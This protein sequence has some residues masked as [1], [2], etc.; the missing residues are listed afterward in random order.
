MPGS[1][2]RR[3]DLEGA[4]RRVLAEGGE[5]RAA[6]C[7]FCEKR[8]AEALDLADQYANARAVEHIARAI[9]PAVGRPGIS[10]VPEPPVR[11]GG[12]S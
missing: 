4:I 9:G 2:Y 12:P 6:P 3:A 8:I 10:P 1:D 7:Q 11:L 5:C